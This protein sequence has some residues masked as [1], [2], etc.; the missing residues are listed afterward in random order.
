MKKNNEI[1][2][3]D[4][5]EIVVAHYNEDLWWLKP[6][7]KNAIVY[8]KWNENE[9]RFPVKKWIK[10][11]NV[12]REWETYLQ[13]IINNYDNLADITIFL[14]WWIKD[15]LSDGFVYKNLNDYIIESRK[16]WFS[17]R[18]L[19]LLL[20]KNPQ[21]KR[22]GKF[23]QAMENWSMKKSEHCFASFYEEIFWKKQPFIMPIF[24]A[25]NFAVTKEKVKG[26]SEA[27]YKK[28]HKYLNLH[29]NPEEWH[30]LERLRFVIFNKRIKLCHIRKILS[31]FCEVIFSK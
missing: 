19:Y 16:H 21:I 4:S 18:R 1:L 27:F 10:L 22:D 3:D 24:F 6:Y 28:I 29:S 11:K 2:L 20:K 25:A 30:F 23:L 5:I 15:H 13:H 14:Q 7:A 17:T 9:P 31:S 26:R 8:H 12:W